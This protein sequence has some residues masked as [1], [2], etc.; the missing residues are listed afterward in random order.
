MRDLEGGL[1]EEEGSALD[2]S[3]NSSLCLFAAIW[4]CLPRGLRGSF[5]PL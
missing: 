3:V 4:G 2:S 1:N 5:C